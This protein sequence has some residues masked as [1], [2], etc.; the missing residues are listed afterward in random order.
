ML[1]QS[2]V[3][4]TPCALSGS[5]LEVWRC[6]LDTEHDACTVHGLALKNGEVE[7]SLDRLGCRS[8]PKRALGGLQLGHSDQ[9]QK[10]RR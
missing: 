9:P 7:G 2:C 10:E 3:S 5:R 8:G 4:S 1:R 6:D